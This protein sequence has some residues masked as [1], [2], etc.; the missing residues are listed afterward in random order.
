MDI[1]PFFFGGCHAG[2]REKHSGWA[3]FVEFWEP[4]PV[5]GGA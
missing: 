2:F 1:D 4:G 5:F 3:G